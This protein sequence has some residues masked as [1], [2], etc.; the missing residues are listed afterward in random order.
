MRFFAIDSAL[1]VLAGIGG[2]G[3]GGFL[4][5]ITEIVSPNESTKPIIAL[6]FA[7]LM[8]AFLFGV[9]AL[10]VKLGQAWRLRAERRV[11]ADLIALEDHKR[12]VMSMKGYRG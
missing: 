12:E 2:A 1:A 7:V 3:I 8:M 9:Y 5:L 11:E 4:A 10:G 6:G